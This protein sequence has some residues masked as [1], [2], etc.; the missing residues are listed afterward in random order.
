MAKN[1]FRKK[2]SG[3]LHSAST[4]S[5][6][7]SVYDNYKSGKLIQRRYY[8]ETGNPRLDID[9][10]NHGNAKNHHVVPHF[11]N[12]NEIENGKIMRDTSYDNKLKLGHIIANKDIL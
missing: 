2:V 4:Y 9:M 11:H 8:G 5:V 7:N 3:E 12:W 10:T 1:S 6:H